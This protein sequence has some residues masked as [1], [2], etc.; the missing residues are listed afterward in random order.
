MSSANVFDPD[1]EPG[2]DDPPGFRSLGARVG[3]PAGSRDLGATVYELPP[4]E[5]LCPYHWHEA[6]E[7]M[8]IVL[9]GSASVRTP[10]GWREVEPGDV[11]AFV[12]GREGAHQI[13]NRG[14]AAARV[15]MVSEMN[16]PEIVFYPDSEKLG[17]M[18]KPP[19]RPI[20]EHEVV[21]RFR[22]GDVVDYWEG[23][24]PPDPE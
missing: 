20:R 2:D 8:A 11:V 10:D 18:T 13:V 5:A 4:G 22:R 14:D 24:R 1:L 12:R 7:E 19:G 6:N 21:E 17:A 3:A 15:L 23:E 9:S 16:S